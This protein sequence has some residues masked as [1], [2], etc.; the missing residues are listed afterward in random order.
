MKEPGLRTS[1]FL[2]TIVALMASSLPATV[3]YTESTGNLYAIELESGAETLLGS[4]LA[5]APFSSLAFAPSGALYGINREFG[6]PDSLFEL[7]PSTGQALRIGDLGEEDLQSLTIDGL[8]QFW[9]H[10]GDALFSVDSSTGL[11]TLAATLDNPVA[12]VAARESTLY[13]V[14]QSGDQVVV[15][16]VDS[17]TGHLTP[18]VTASPL[19]GGVTGASFD[20]SGFLRLMT[21]YGGGTLNV[22]PHGFYR[23]SLTTGGLEETY[24]KAYG[25]LDPIASMQALAVPGRGSVTSVPSLQPALLL[26]LTAIM[27]AASVVLIRR[28]RETMRAS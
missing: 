7:D 28:R 25:F 3:G 27:A 9:G 4:T 16:V 12:V 10:R 6:V 13:A 8:G 20:P 17:A 22:T 1:I 2:A 5:G 19:F 11:A 24:F 26:L 18:A 21:L 23:L 14:S 15:D